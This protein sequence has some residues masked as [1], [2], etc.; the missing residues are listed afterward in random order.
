[1]RRASLIAVALATAIV[2]LEGRAISSR[3]ADLRC[4]GSIADN[5]RAVVREG[6]GA[7]DACHVR[8]DAGRLHAD[9]NRL[10]SLVPAP[11]AFSSLLK[12]FRIQSARA[13]GIIGATC[14]VSGIL[15][16]YPNTTAAGDIANVVGH[17]IQREIEESGVALEGAPDLAGE[18][19]VNRRCHVA[20]GRARTAIVLDTI[21]VAIRCQRALDHS[22]G[23]LGA[24]AAECLG[25]TTRM[26]ARAQA[27]LVRACDGVAGPE[28]GSCAP[29]PDC[30]VAEAV[31]AGETLARDFYG[32]TPAQRDTLCGNGFIDLGEDCDDGNTDPTDACTNTCQAAQCG[33]GIVEVGVEQCDDGNRVNDD[34]CSNKCTQTTCGDGLVQAGEECDDGNNVP[35]DGCTD[36]M[37]DP[38]PC[39]ADGLDARVCLA[40]T[41]ATAQQIGG[42]T[43]DVS[44]PASLSIPGSGF[45]SSVRQRVMDLTGG[46]GL[47]AIVD[48]DEN[49]DGVD[50]TL[51]NAYVTTAP[52]TVP[53]GPFE[54]IHFDCPAGTMVRAHDVPCVISD[55][56]DTLGGPITD[57]MSLPLCRVGV[58]P[59]GDTPNV[60]CPAP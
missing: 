6:L 28:V 49:G 30:V 9:C 15:T 57:P 58:A 20:I 26:T 36:C 35:N 50:D 45:A 5:L 11:P 4:R 54:L 39:N 44:Y 43:V 55:A 27:R 46:V 14:G 42:V 16:N 31:R 13:A 1:M 53:F 10:F 38:V 23:E 3:R 47:S 60:D 32:A 24:I 8:R 12:G 41:Q 25:H 34:A 33:D 52:R 21:R 17:A 29:L 48:R 22:M 59:H 7:L 19:K 37:L 18:A 51:R 40:Q 2:F 56:S